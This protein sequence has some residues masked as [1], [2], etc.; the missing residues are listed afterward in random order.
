MQYTVAKVAASLIAFLM[1]WVVLGATAVGLAVTFDPPPDGSIPFTVAMMFFF[2]AN[3]CALLALLLIT[4]SEYWAIAG[5]LLSNFGIAAYM[6][7]VSE[8]PS[9]A[10]NSDGPVAV[11]STTVLTIIAI[12]AAVAALSLG[13]AFYVQARRK[14]FV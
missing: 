7:I 2:L 14:D 4:R 10:A 3:F 9:I 11:W 6:N 5:I 13:L 8:L 12:E 1:P